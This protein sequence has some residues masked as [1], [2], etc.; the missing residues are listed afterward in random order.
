MKLRERATAVGFQGQ[1]FHC[2]TGDVLASSSEMGGDLIRDVEGYD[3]G[4]FK[5]RIARTQ[6][7]HE[8]AP[9]ERSDIRCAEF[10]PFAV[11]S[12]HLK[13]FVP[14]RFDTFRVVGSDS[15]NRRGSFGQ[16]YLELVLPT[17]GRI[18]FSN[19]VEP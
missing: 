2:G 8:F 14:V 6:S 5:N 13:P 1:R 12:S 16:L 17:P 10:E 9:L 7:S 15:V 3:H 11:L 4:A 19:F 18:S